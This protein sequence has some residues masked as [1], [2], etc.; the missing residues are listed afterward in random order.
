MT[1]FMIAPLAMSGLAADIEP[2]G[3]EDDDALHDQLEEEGANRMFMPL[4]ITPITSAPSSVPIIV[5][6]PPARLVPPS[7]TAAVASSS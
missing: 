3:D 2:Q 4:L 7:T 1:F 5:P 6:T